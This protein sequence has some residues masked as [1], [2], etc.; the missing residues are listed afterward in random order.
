MNQLE[1][2]GWPGAVNAWRVRPG[3]WRMG[4]AEWLTG[5]GWEAL[6]ADGVRHVVDLRMPHEVGRKEHDPAP[7]PIPDGVHRIPAPIEEPDDPDFL[8]LDV[9][10][11]DHPKLYDDAVRIFPE[12]VGAALSR[13]RDA[14][15]D[16]GV[17]VHCSAGRDR[18]GMMLALLLQLDDIPGG[19]ATWEEQ[20]ANYSTAVRGMNEFWGTT[21]LTHPIERYYPPEEFEPRLAERVEA[22]RV[23]LEDW[24]KERVERLMADAQG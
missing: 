5:E 3:L 18:T 8:A 2:A 15:R 22:L 16:G 14:W 12:K 9:P 23:F 20:A 11:V 24:P 19:A 17:V 13:I 1:P 21:S 4:R 7:A 6:A 10:Y